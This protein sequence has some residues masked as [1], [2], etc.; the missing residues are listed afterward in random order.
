MQT[1]MLRFDQILKIQE[2]G[3]HTTNSLYTHPSRNLDWDVFLYIAEGQM[4]V[5]EDDIEYVIKKGQFLFLKSGLSHWGEPKTPAGTSWYWIHFTGHSNIEALHELN[6]NL[7]ASPAVSDSQEGY[8]KFITLPKYGTLSQPK[9]MENRLDALVQL[10][11]SSDPFR[12]IALSL[13]SMEMYVNLYKDSMQEHQ[14]T[15]SDRTVLRIIDY[16]EHKN[17]YELD[18]KE[19]A[20]SLDMNYSY[21]CEIFKL[22]TGNTIQQYNARLFMNKA[23]ELMKDSH[24]NVSE[25]SE[26]LG[27]K[28]PFYFSRVFSK[29][30]GCSP[31][32][33][34]SRIYRK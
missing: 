19:L 5:W 14:P 18:S 15:K 17:N 12:T 9:I 28:N 27:F 32:E 7:Y 13:Q 21:L 24:R 3:F 33:Y 1:V 23:I 20:A 2:F 25:I 26:L 34:M 29:I 10:F 8:Q 11:H 22:K 6:I 30:M 31:S 16:L 4:E